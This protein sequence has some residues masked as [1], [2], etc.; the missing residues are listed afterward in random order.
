MNIFN[1]IN[2]VQ[3]NKVNIIAQFNLLH[4]I[5]SPYKCT[6]HINIHHYHILH[7][8]MNTCKGRA[9]YKTFKYYLMVY[10]VPRF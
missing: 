7:K 5:I 6:K 2:H 10:V 3:D 4:D 1:D 8:C 9:N